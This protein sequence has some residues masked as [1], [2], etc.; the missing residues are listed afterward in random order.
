[1]KCKLCNSSTNFG[2]SHIIPESFFL[3]E[4]KDGETPILATNTPGVFPKRRPIGEYDGS[5]LCKECEQLFGP[6][7]NYAK[8]LLFDKFSQFNLVAE[9]SDYSAYSIERYDYHKLKLFCLS[10]LWRAGVSDR[11]CFEKVSLGPHE[12]ILRNM[13]LSSDPG[14]K[15]QY[16]VQLMRFHG[17]PHEFPVIMP[18]G[19]RTRYKFNY[20][21]IYLGNFFFDVK[22]DKRKT[23]VEHS[24]G[25]L[26]D[27]SPLIIVSKN[28]KD[29]DEYKILKMVANAPHNATAI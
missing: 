3:S 18:I 21:R 16:S 4:R 6:W 23:P 29:M 25:E 17:L 5:I 14:N 2:K 12:Q 20:H 22:T 11:E 27:G 1:V 26:E 15:D 8:V 10:V 28:I 19:F 13:I 7:D 9:E 24:G